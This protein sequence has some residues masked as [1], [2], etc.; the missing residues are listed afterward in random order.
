[1]A[2][3]LRHAVDDDVT[4][5]LNLTDGQTYIAQ[6]RGH[7]TVY[8]ASIT[9]TSMPDN[10]VPAFRVASGETVVLKPASGESIWTWTADTAGR[11]S[12]LIIGQ[13]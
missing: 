8:V 7:I 5:V 2:A 10:T 12:E 3:T 6:N 4:Q 1:M 11:G 13:V 9:G